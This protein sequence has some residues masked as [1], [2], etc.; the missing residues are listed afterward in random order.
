MTTIVDNLSL[1]VARFFGRR[2]LAS[3]DCGACAQASMRR[4]GSQHGNDR[5]TTGFAHRIE[6]RKGALA[7]ALTKR[8]FRYQQTSPPVS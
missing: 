1:A 8:S 6:Q 7:L 2:G 3:S 4:S 5:W